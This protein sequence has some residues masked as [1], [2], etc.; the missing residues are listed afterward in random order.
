MCV[1][2]SSSRISGIAW[3]DVKLFCG[4]LRGSPFGLIFG[5]IGMGIGGVGGG[6][7]R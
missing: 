2:G 7:R 3:L 4:R 5:E 6:G 1:E